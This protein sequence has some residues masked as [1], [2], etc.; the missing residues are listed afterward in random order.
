MTHQLHDR[1]DCA[2]A[3][4]RFKAVQSIHLD[5]EHTKRN[6][7]FLKSF[8][9]LENLSFGIGVRQ[10][11]SC[12]IHASMSLQNIFSIFLPSEGFH[13]L[14]I[15]SGAKNASAIVS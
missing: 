15:F 5:R 12:R 11:A 6:F 14:E 4:L 8:E 7:M 10:S 2:A 3:V 9:V 1:G 13:G